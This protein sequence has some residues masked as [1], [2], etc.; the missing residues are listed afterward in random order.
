M[1]Q[2]FSEEIEDQNNDDHLARNNNS[3]VGIGLTN[4]KILTK[5]MGGNISIL[6]EVGEG[7]TVTFSIDARQSLKGTNL[8]FESV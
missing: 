4:S 7:T 6:S 5:A 8:S 2:A 1:F 3:G